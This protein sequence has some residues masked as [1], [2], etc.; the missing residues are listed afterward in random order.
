MGHGDEKDVKFNAPKLVDYFSKRG[1]KIKDV[2][3]GEYH[4]AALTED[5]EVYTWGYAGK[6]G[7]FN[8]LYS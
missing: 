3:L 4:S 6:V 7:L 1:K 5:G 2:A 8:W